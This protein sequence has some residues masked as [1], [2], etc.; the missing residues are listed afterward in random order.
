MAGFNLKRIA[1]RLTTKWQKPYS[2]TCG[3]FKS[4]IAI[5]LVWAT[6]LCI[7]GYKVMEHWISMQIPQWEDSAVLNLF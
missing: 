4:R 6:H 5:T 2:R 7:Q 3:Y 1:I